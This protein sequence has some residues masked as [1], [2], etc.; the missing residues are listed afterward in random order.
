[1]RR[2][3][4]RRKKCMAYLMAV[5]P[6]DVILWCKCRKDAL[7]LSNDELS[8]LS[9]V[10]KGTV[11]RLFSA[12]STDFRFSTVQPIIRALSGC[13]PDA[14]DCE[15]GEPDEA[16]AETLCAKEEMI[17]ALKEEAIRQTD[18]ISHLQ[19]KAR[20]D[21]ERAKDEEAKSLAYMKK[22]EKGHIKAIIILA[23]ALAVTLLAIIAALV[24]DKL[25]PH[26]GF[27]WLH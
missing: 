15:T 2:M 13:E 23:I 22:K 12:R 20:E 6:K 9:G 11:D 14:L 1:M 8:S 21:M 27:F 10:P 3:Q 7:R 18:Y 26:I 5:S 25:N 16:H 17:I 19:A 4:P 24:I